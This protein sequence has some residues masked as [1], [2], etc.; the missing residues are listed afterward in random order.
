MKRYLEN[1]MLRQLLTLLALISGL[2]LTATPAVAAQANVVSVAAA[3]ETADCQP[4]TTQPMQLM[5]ETPRNQQKQQACGQHPV[6]IWTPTV[7]LQ[8]DRARE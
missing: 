4:V 6:I 2:G 1:D 5:R 7:Q 3:G 8:A